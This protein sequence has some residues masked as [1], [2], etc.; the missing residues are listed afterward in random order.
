M[1]FCDKGK[2]GPRRYLVPALRFHKQST[3]FY[4]DHLWIVA[5]AHDHLSIED[6]DTRYLRQRLPVRYMSS[7]KDAGYQPSVLTVFTRILI[8]FSSPIEF[9]SC[10]LR[11]NSISSAYMRMRRLV[12]CFPHGLARGGPLTHSCRANLRAL[13]TW[14]FFTCREKPVSVAWRNVP[15]PA[16]PG[17]L[18]GHH[19][20]TRLPSLS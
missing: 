4:I 20:I 10:F 14:P 19:R 15:S 16:F 7:Q 11:S 9:S 18:K 13:L 12:G 3:H 1:I 2:W 17:Q 6:V 8:E 5:L